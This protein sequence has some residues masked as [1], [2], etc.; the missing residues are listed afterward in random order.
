MHNRAGKSTHLPLFIFVFTAALAP[1]AANSA[2]PIKAPLTPD[3]WNLIGDAGFT[4]RDGQPVIELKAGNYAQHIRTGVAEL[5]DLNFGNGTIEFDVLATGSMGA[6]FGFRRTDDQNFEDFYLR[7]RDNCDKA[8]DCIQYAPNTHGVLL[9]DLFPQYQSP[10]P[11]KNNDWN[12]LKFVIN[13]QR[14]N[15]F[16]NGA[17]TPTFQIGRLEGDAAEGGILLQGPGVFANLVITPDATEGLSPNPLP[18][19]VANDA[20]LIRRWQLS[21]YSELAADKEPTISD[22][23]A[24]TAAWQPIAAER[25]GLVDISRVYGVPL[26]RPK[27]ALAW[28]KTTI[29]SAKDETRTVQ[30]GWVR[31]AWVFVN[32]K[33]VYADKN[34]YP[35]PKTRK[36]PDGRCSLQNGSFQLPLKRGDNEVDIA[37][38]NNF[39][40]WAIQFRLDDVKGIRFAGE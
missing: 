3:R 32:G 30:F 25:A 19:P 38:A 14:M 16:V 17:T 5:K 2:G 23:P 37:L 31:E 21:P 28:L 11:V 22:L 18:D 33:L 35:D 1:A 9:W 24:A 6:G 20:R 26:D 10:A 12:H 8:E 13:G 27:L 34:L 40:G 7:P 36:A 29:H 4:T 15:I 39:Y